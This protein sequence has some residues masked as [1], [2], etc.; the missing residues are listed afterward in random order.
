MM[1]PFPVAAVVIA[2]LG[3]AL[4]ARL[5]DRADLWGDE[6]VSWAVASAPL[7]E[8]PSRCVDLE[9]KPPLYFLL[10]HGWMG[11]GG[12]SERA[13][14]SLSLMAWPPFALLMIVLGRR[15]CGRWALLPLFLA[16]VSPLLGYYGVEARPYAMLL[17]A[18]TAFL[19]L[20]VRAD[21][22]PSP[23]S[24]ALLAGGSFL[25]LLLQFTGVF[26]VVPVFLA[27]LL[28]HRRDP[29][30]VA[31]LLIPQVV[32]AGI[33]VIVVFGIPG[34][35]RRLG[36]LDREWWA[37]YPS[38]SQVLSAPVRLLAP[39]V[40]WKSY[41][42]PSRPSNVLLLPCAGFLFMLAAGGLW[43]SR[44]RRFL[45]TAGAAVLGLV[46]VYSLFRANLLFER[47][48]IG[49]A[50]VLLLGVGSALE[51]CSARWPA[52]WK[53]LVPAT[54]LSSIV[55]LWMLPPFEGAARYRGPVEVI[56]SNERGRVSILTAHWDGPSTRY[57]SRR[58]KNR[59]RFFDGSAAV[60][61][62]IAD[63]APLFYLRSAAWG[64]R[65]GGMES[66]LLR[67]AIILVPVYE[68][69]GTIVFRVDRGSPR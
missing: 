4:R 67:R 64:G 44:N 54:V 5:L 56:L 40:S 3:L 57:Y 29:R 21:E 61:E 48:Y 15:F 62:A 18:E 47:Y 35:A 26:Y 16:S 46:V 12:D 55:L 49:V 45:M 37:A 20:A 63:P 24:R 53:A 2:L 58:E 14:R 33:Y 50:P 27:L 7:S 1:R 28:R 13:L 11:I 41:I 9:A 30:E 66:F 10:L 34:M 19:W 39:V 31:R 52:S 23:S 36:G 60:G 17:T 8:V 6:A 32:A 43:I 51:G 69:G 59:I 68:G 25:V 42:D 38:W 22:D 65:G